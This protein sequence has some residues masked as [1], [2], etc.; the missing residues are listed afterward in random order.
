MLE[1][2]IRSTDFESQNPRI[3]H[4]VTTRSNGYSTSSYSSFNLGKWCGE[5]PETTRF[6][7]KLLGKE[8]HIDSNNIIVPREVHSNETVVIDEHFLRCG[9]V[10][11]ERL[12]ATADA[13]VTRLPCV[14]IGVTTADCVPI[15]GYNSNDT[16]V[17]IH[18][19]WR[20]IVAGV[21]ESAFKKMQEISPSQDYRFLVG[22]CIDGDSYEVGEDVWQQFKDRFTAAEQ[23]KILRKRVGEKFFPDIRTAASIQ[24][25]Q[26]CR[27]NHIKQIQIDTYSNLN[28]YSVR[29]DG[30][31]T[32][33]FVTGIMLK[34]TN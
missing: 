33:R 29:R 5:D 17:A 11:R 6:N 28:F 12:L 27:T 32:G 16:I 19:G 23:D 2:I 26:H 34:G 15:I 25:E 7:Y 3:D 4:F 18:A 8:L 20:G 30:L 21:I 24:L 9:L 31:K 13:L 22:P 14:A 1:R 10:E